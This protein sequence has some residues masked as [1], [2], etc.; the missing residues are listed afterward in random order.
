VLCLVFEA[1]P[2]LL[3]ERIRPRCEDKAVILEGSVRTEQQKKRAELDAWSLFG[4]DRVLNR[5]Q[6]TD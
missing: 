6:V 2:L 4:V 5:L 1:V 3:A